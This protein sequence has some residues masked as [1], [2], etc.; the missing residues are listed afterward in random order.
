MFSS[1]RKAGLIL[2]LTAVLLSACAANN[3]E[4]TVNP[5]TIY[6]SAAMTVE[7]QLTEAA[8]LNPTSTVTVMI[9]TE[10]ATPTVTVS[11]A[12]NTTPGG[13]ANPLVT[14]TISMLPTF[15]G[16]APVV[17]APKG[18]YEVVGQS[19]ADETKIAPG[20][21]F[22]MSWTIKNTGTDTWQKDFTIQFFS[23]NRIGGGIFTD[24]SY[25]FGKEV[26]P[27]ETITLTVEM[28][29]PDTEDTYYSWWKLKDQYGGNFGDVDVTIIAD[30]D[31]AH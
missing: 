18:K 9:P 2:V 14:S 1:L 8:K 30:F 4:P 17:S 11:N 10:T 26:K 20:T 3:Q 27:G 21:T 22:E 29:V 5:D 16:T 19:P 15:T 12:G 25:D 28:S 31:A 7:A 6:T 13:T 24:N 23:G